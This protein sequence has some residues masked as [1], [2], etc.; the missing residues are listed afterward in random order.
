[1]QPDPHELAAAWLETARRDVRDAAVLAE[2]SANTACF[3]SQQAA[4]KAFKA[5]LIFVA[6]DSPRSHRTPHLLAEAQALQLGVLPRVRDALL[7]LEKHY[8]PTRYP[9]ALGGAIP[10][11]V[12]T[13]AEA[14]AAI[15]SATTV[16]DDVARQ[17]DG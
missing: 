13:V 10:G 2:T 16:I 5:L 15:E 9:D 11:D 6:G 14:R 7:T 1:M 3:L 12:Y 8:I 4:E 17:L